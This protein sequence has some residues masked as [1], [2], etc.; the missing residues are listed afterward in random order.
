MAKVDS[1]GRVVLPQSVREQL[2]IVPGTEVEIREKDGRAVIEPEK[3][4]EQIIE[5]MESLI[6]DAAASRTSHSYDDLDVIARDHADTIRRQ[7]RG[8]ERD[9][10]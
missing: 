7:A 10:E 1:K 5:R 9:D 3:D 8:S 4:P 6:D 2:G